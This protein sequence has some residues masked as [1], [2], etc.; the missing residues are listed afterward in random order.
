MRAYASID[1]HN[2]FR[3]LYQ[4][5]GHQALLAM[6][7]SYCKLGPAKAIPPYNYLIDMLQSSGMGKSRT[8]DM[9]AQKW[10]AFLLNLRDPGQSVVS[11]S[12][13]L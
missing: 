3:D 2:T 13:S 11:V 5:E 4:G 8:V 6:M 7:D 10:F 1:I 12:C 9:V